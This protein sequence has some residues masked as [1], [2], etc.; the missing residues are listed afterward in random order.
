MK[1]VI[2]PPLRLFA[3]LTSTASCAAENPVAWRL[4]VS[5]NSVTLCINPASR[6]YRRLQRTPAPRRKAQFPGSSFRPI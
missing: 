5:S 6:R 4:R 1:A 3:S 2:I